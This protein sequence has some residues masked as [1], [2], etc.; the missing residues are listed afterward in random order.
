M[1]INSLIF[2]V[3]ATNDTNTLFR[4]KDEFV[5][6]KE[7]PVLEFVKE[8]F[9][10][11]NKL[12]DYN[13][14]E[15]KCSVQLEDNTE[16][17]QYWLDEII[18]KYKESVIEKAVIDSAKDRSSAI[19]N[20]QKALI[21]VNVEVDSRIANYSEGARRAASYDARKGTGGVTY[22][23]T[24]RE[25]LDDFSLGFKRADLWTIGGHEGI[26]KSWLLLRMA[27]AVDQY[28]IDFSFD[29]DILIVSGEM[30]SSEM[31]ERLDTI[32]CEVSYQRLSRGELTPAEERKY[33]RYLLGFDSNIRIV[34][35]FDNL[36]DIDYLMTVYQPAIVFLDGSH[37]LSSSY[38]WTDIARVTAG[39]K[40]MTR[41]K[42]IP[43]VN[44]T[45]LK[46]DRGKS[47]KGGDIDD[48]AY[49]KGYTRDSDIVG[50]MY[51]SDMMA[52]ENKIGVDWVK[53]RRGQRT[54]HI[55]QNDYETSTMSLLET[56]VGKQI[57]G[58]KR[59]GQPDTD[60]DY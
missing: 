3:I 36:K 46:G 60:F 35:S 31:E 47:A 52:L 15:V 14:V 44:T 2:S 48:F 37:L 17:S 59:G 42:K 51:A 49:T 32:R 58:G 54:Q 33:K 40:K 56:K 9:R 7:L 20:F 13:T 24:G 38:E 28:F 25:E 29:K 30:E 18:E 41:N 16:S 23:S 39:M 27:D 21:D 12:P 50:V 53:V 45:H 26:G 55:F 6:A 4:T 57:G 5:T 34:D 43:I 1:L 22:I 8:Y 11:Y 10:K 19:D